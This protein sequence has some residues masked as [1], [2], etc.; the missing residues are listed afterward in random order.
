MSLIQLYYNFTRTCHIFLTMFLIN[1]A[2]SFKSIA[3]GIKTHGRFSLQFLRLWVSWI[4]LLAILPGICSAQ[5]P[6]KSYN[7]GAYIID[8]GQPTQT[9]ANGLKPYGLVYAFIQGGISVD[10]SINS[11]KLKDGTDFN[12]VTSANGNKAYK[13][14][15]FIIPF[16]NVNSTVIALINTWK[17]LGVVVDGPTTSSF[18]AP[19]FKT[20]S[21]WPRAFLDAA[22]DQL[23]QPYYANAGVPT[24]SYVI[25]ANPTMLPQCGSVS[26]ELDVYILPHADPNLWDATWIAALQYFINNGGSMWAGC[27][28]VSV[29]E[30]LPGCNFLS[31]GGLVPFGS[32]TNGTPPYT[33]T[34]P[35][36]PFMQFIGILDGAT[37]N[38]SEQIYVPGPLGWRA[39]T[40]I[41][42]YDPNYVNASITYPTTAA[43][44]AYGPA[45]GTK[46]LVMYEAAHQLNQSGTIAEQVAAQRAFFNFLL[47]AG[48]QTQQSVTPPSISNQTATTCSGAAFSVTPAGAPSNT[49]Y[50]WIAPAGTGFTGGSAQTT[51][52]SSISQTLTNTGTTSATAIYTVTPQIGGCL[53]NTFTVSVT[54]LAPPLLSSTLTPASICSGTTFSYTATSAASGATFSWTRAVVA[55]IS[56]GAGSGSTASISEILTNTTAAAVVVTYAI[57]TTAYGCANT[58]NVTVTVNPVPA[59]PTAVTATPGAICAGGSSNLKATSVGNT[60]RWYTVATGGSS[61][62][63]SGSGANFLVSPAGTTT[64]YA[65]ASISASGCVSTTRSAVTVTVTPKPVLSSTLT[66]ADICSKTLFSYTATSSTTGATFGWTRAVVPGISNPAGNGPTGVIS[67]TLINTTTAPVVV[68]YAITTTANGCAS[69]QNVTVKVNAAP[70][71]LS[72]TGSTICTSPGLNGKITST[73][74][75]SGVNYQLYNGSGVAQGTAVAGTGSGLTWTAVAAG[76]GYSVV[77]TNS[78]TSCT[79]TSATVNIGTYTNPAVT[80]TSTSPICVGSK[81]ALTGGPG[82]MTTYSWTGPS[83]YSNST[84]SPTVS[85][86]ATTAMGGTYSLTVTDS[87]GCQGTASVAATVNAIPDVT[88]FSVAGSTTCTGSSAVV[89]VSSSSLVT[90]TY[91]VTYNVTGPNSKASTTASMSFTAGSPGTGTFIT[92]ALNIDGI[93]NNVVQITAIA[94]SSSPLCTSAVS[95][96]KGT[97]PAFTTH[98]CIAATCIFDSNGTYNF[99]APAGVTSITIQAWGAGGGGETTALYVDAGAGGGGGGA[100]TTLTNFPVTSGTQYAVVVGNG[101]APGFAGTNSTFNG[102]TVV[103][104]GGGS[105]STADCN[106]CTNSGGTGGLASAPTGGASFSGGNGGLGGP[107][108]GGKH[109]G[110]GGGGSA[111]AGSAGGAG[112]VYNG[113]FGGIGGTAGTGTP[114][115]AAGGAGGNDQ[116]KT[117]PFNGSDGS[118]PGAGGGGSGHFDNSHGPYVS[119]SGADGEVKI[120]YYSAC[121][122]YSLTSTSATSPCVGNAATVTLNGTVVTL[123]IGTY[124]VTYNLSGTNTATGSTATMTITSAGTGTFTTP[125][126]ANSGST[127]VTITNLSSG[128]CSVCSSGISTNNTAIITVYPNS[129]GGTAAATSPTICYN[130]NTS[131]AVTGYTGTIQWQQSPDGNTGWTNVTGGSGATSATYTTPALTATTYYRA[132]VTSG[133]CSSDYSTT[134]SVTVNELLTITGTTPASICGT[135]TVILGATASAGTVNWYAAL[136]GGSSLGT[137]TSFTTPSLSSTTTY[138]A[139]ASSN[140]CVSAARTAVTAT[141]NPIPTISSATVSPAAVCASGQVVF[142]ATPSSGSITWYDASS[143][144]NVVDLLNPI[145]STTTTYY[146][147]AWA[148]GCVSASRTAI[149][150][151]VNALPTVSSASVSPTAVCVSGQVV[152][153]A[154]PSSGTITWY[155]AATNGN[156]VTVLNP[157]IS[158]TTTY[159]AEASAN[160]CVS[161]NRTAVTATVNPLPTVS[162]ASV[163]PASV[164]VSG[165]VVFSAT[166]S[167]GTITWYDAATNGNVVTVLNPTISATT[168]YYAEAS[169]NG[170][171]SAARTAVTATVNALPTVSNAS[172]S[173]ASVCASGQV[174][175]SATPSAGTIKWYDDP[176]SGNVVT[177]LN[178][179]ITETTT[180]YAEASANGCE[181][182]IRTAVTSTVN[183]FPTATIR[184]SATICGGS[185]ATITVD[186]SGNQPWSIT[187]TDGTSPVKINSIS[188][189]SYTFN[190]SP[191]TNK[192]YSLTAV[193][194][195]NCTGTFSGSAIITIYS[196]LVPGAHNTDP[197]TECTG[198]NPAELSFTTAISGGQT[199][200][201][202]QWQLNNN[203]IVGATS[204]TYDS[205]QLTTAGVYSFN[206]VVTDGCGSTFTTLPKVITIVPDP[207]VSILGSTSVCQN[208][209]I[210]L[211]ANI[212]N[213]TGNYN[214]QWRSG[215]SVS[216]PWTDIIGAT[217]ITY[218]PPASNVGT[219]YYQVFINPSHPECNQT[220]STGFTLIVNALPSCSINGSGSVFA[221]STGNTYISTP[222]PSDN[223][224][225][226]WSI[227]G[228]GIISGS[229]TGPTVTVN[230][231]AVGS[232]TITDN[233]SRFGCT[234]LCTYSVYVIDLPC[235]ITPSIS[236]PNGISTIYTAPAGMDTYSWSI[237]GNGSFTSGVN[238]QTVIVLAG[239]NCNTYAL[240]VTIAKSGASSTCTQTIVVSDNQPPTFT[241]PAAISE[242]VEGLYSAIYNSATMDINP[243]RP[244]YFT[245]G[246][247]NTML[248]LTGLSDN[249]CS[250]GSLLISWRIDFY[251]GVTASITGTGQPSAYGSPI[252]F[253]G[254]GTTFLNVTHS[255]TYWVTDCNGNISLPQTTTITIKPRPNVIT[256]N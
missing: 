83:S 218:N 141:V 27:H 184:G 159:Y 119:G 22:N 52:Q 121:P 65:E 176:T 220:T 94:F 209:N 228:N 132:M 156:V 50:T 40:T 188:T 45:F 42:V 241:P 41:S 15:P 235:S 138:Y 234:S 192:T 224:N 2:C 206:C 95:A 46:G 168:T 85:A 99:S 163:S 153:S 117:T 240:T 77:G 232:F 229:N 89:T 125:L 182:A 165:Q 76:T 145:I 149:T 12:A 248:D 136:T 233:I 61:I 187:Y 152:F 79:S 109:G 93:L 47:D 38:G 253:P 24:A 223:V 239:N 212:T 56:N 122:T 39:T 113:D 197:L 37:Q 251:G 33:Y 115:G 64:Y 8:M 134:A 203:P 181:S 32:H 75:V 242:C 158:T 86:S 231:T 154:I 73:T 137:G 160:G 183:P 164:C 60:I 68:T 48:T 57:T 28:A 1:L 191:G 142:S 111:G 36:N 190:V 18:T 199:P 170:C 118:A 216:G 123:P 214:Y 29:L 53:G 237:I 35:S 180:Y 185:F 243:G 23:I 246:T 106:N 133:T 4:I 131:I 245:L 120:I 208:G 205:P 81:L 25:N 175:F 238:S 88:S 196:T 108:G 11:S 110:G 26:G 147:E 112:A 215:I 204:A 162:S 67:E 21:K 96:A 135:G 10:W 143:N 92:P 157:T 207:S 20:L 63:T 128:T 97:T 178:P 222:I 189:S 194:D 91:A 49:N 198:Y 124:T 80:A 74:S 72:L 146:A 54:I 130:I 127:T 69:T 70:T 169:A 225:H 44:I 34:S 172:V 16:E 55:G 211:T 43:I 249:C 150:A 202:Y 71:A 139:E 177:V 58:Q 13:G 148:N 171:T 236:V 66:P 87:H 82:A 155:D 173:P 179:T 17:A 230:A 103:A 98:P 252:Q 213:G 250:T 7:A 84:Q 219:Y 126:L 254:D 14:G 167:S 200:Y 195:A 6:T 244:D 3:T 30:N 90:G 186:L 59:A 201:N 226:L 255:I 256:Q 114:G 102:T 116:S 221:G 100:Y 247:G 9:I 151:T 227:S 19:F 62:G 174:V 51:P 217:S 31:N 104:A 129:V 193:N 107:G 78:A 210:T 144:G 101:G 140:G 5:N 166:P 105:N 161:L